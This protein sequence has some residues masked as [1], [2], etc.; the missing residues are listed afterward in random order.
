[1]QKAKPNWR[2]WTLIQPLTVPRNGATSAHPRRMETTMAR[3]ADRIRE[4]VMKRHVRPFLKSDEATL[5]IRAGDV[6]KDMELG[7]RTPAVCSALEGRKF[8]QE[9]GLV[10]VCRKG[11]RQSTTTTFHYER[12]GKPKAQAEMGAPQAPVRSP[13]KAAAIQPPRG[14]KLPA[15]DLCLVS[16]VSRKQSHRALAKDM[17]ASDW[18]MKARTLVEAQGW[19]WF[20]LS[21]QHGL[22]HPDKKIAPYEKTLNNMLKA[23]RQAWADDVMEALERH[24]GAVRTI[25]FFAGQRYREF[26]APKLQKRGIQCDVPMEGLKI[27]E[28]LAWLNDGIKH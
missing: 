25:V 10:Y 23:E 11:P 16:C 27:G 20:I 2:E 15:A 6:V 14:A 13:S 19:P 18:F 5:S 26:L 1:M 21:A 12:A 17:Y 28:Q 24:L 4:H 7:N 8:W 9:A 3:L 22:L